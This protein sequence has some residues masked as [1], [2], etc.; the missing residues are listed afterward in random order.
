[1]EIKVGVDTRTLRRRLELAGKTFNP[2]VLV[3]AIGEAELRWI[4][5][6]FRTEGGKVGGWRPLSPN[7]IAAKGSSRILQDTGE[8]RKSFVYHIISDRIVQ[9]GSGKEYASYHERGTRPYIIRPRN[10]RWELTTDKN[11]NKRMVRKGMLSFITVDGRVFATQ[12]RHPGLPKRRMLPTVEEA[13]EIARK[14]VE[15]A[16]RK[17]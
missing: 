15:A 8:L 17:I 5:E 6:N 9:V 3:R 14:L 16:A 4:N 10:L 13:K 12:V 11:G 7:T 2:R 1:M